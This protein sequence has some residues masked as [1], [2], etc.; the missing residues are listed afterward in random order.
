MSDGDVRSSVRSFLI[1]NF[2]LGDDS[3]DDSASL[4]ESG[5]VDSTGIMELVAFLEVSFDIQVSDH[6]LTA[7][8]LDSVDRIVGYVEGKRPATAARPEAA[9]S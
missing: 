1:E 9:A 3:L 8:N 6:E 5:V 4:L 2:M 7:D